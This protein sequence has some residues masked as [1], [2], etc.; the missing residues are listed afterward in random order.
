[1]SR[2]YWTSHRLLQLTDVQIYPKCAQHGA[3][4][5]SVAFCARRQRRPTDA[6][7][8]ARVREVRRNSFL[9]VIF[10]HFWLPHCQWPVE[11]T[12]S[13]GFRPPRT[14]G[15]RW[16]LKSCHGRVPAPAP[17]SRKPGVRGCFD[18]SSGQQ[19]AERGALGQKSAVESVSTVR[20]SM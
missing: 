10:V 7:L 13:A 20:W 16:Q 9:C 14:L 3:F 4:L 17:R 15:S 19:V 12:T 11:I 2:A 1:M 8:R 18:S 6:S 5:S